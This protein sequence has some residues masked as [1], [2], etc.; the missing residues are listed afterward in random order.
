MSPHPNPYK[1][2][3]QVELRGPYIM[4][5]FISFC[6]RIHYHHVYFNTRLYKI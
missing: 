3:R 2:T 5:D 4:I 6:C 1:V